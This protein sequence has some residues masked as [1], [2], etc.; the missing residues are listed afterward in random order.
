MLTSE[1][2]HD[3]EFTTQDGTVVTIESRTD[4]AICEDMMDAIVRLI[5]RN[6]AGVDSQ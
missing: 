2:N 4:P 1:Y 3:H 6:I 5:K